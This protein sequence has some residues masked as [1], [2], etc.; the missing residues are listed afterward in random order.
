[1]AD[2]ERNELQAIRKDITEI[3]STLAEVQKSLK[4]SQ[5]I[6]WRQFVFGIGL[7]AMVVGMS[8]TGCRD[9]MMGFV[10]FGIGVV[11]CL[12][13]FPPRKVL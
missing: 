13:S 3:K 4:R 10:I 11:F 7:T 12:I 9:T 8:L 5:N 2:S 6:G 1:M